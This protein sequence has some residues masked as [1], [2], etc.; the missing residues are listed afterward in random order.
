MRKIS[1]GDV[2]GELTC[3]GLAPTPVSGKRW[4]FRCACGKIVAYRAWQVNSGAV[5]SCGCRGGKWHIAP[6]LIGQTF[7]RL[8]VVSR[9]P[10]CGPRANWLC[11][12]RCG[13]TISVP[14]SHLRGGQQSCGC[15][16]KVGREQMIEK[17]LS[18]R[19]IAITGCWEWTGHVNPAG[20]GVV[21]AKS[22]GY[23]RAM[24]HRMAAHFWIGMPLGSHL[25]VCHRCDN[26]KCFNPDHLF[27]GTARDN[28]LD[29][30]A[31]GRMDPGG[32]R[33]HP[34]THCVNGHP[35]NPENRISKGKITACRECNR[36]RCNRY[37]SLKDVGAVS[38]MR[39][40]VTVR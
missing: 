13:E 26:R 18:R 16:L 5:N 35:V 23:A 30:M 38:A 39:L 3:I 40:A 14:T 32:R 21:T 7:G 10:N 37:R 11:R 15:I 17:L 6:D 34:R 33:Q 31:K 24:V 20:Y 36:I 1:V 22:F 4:L 28:A 19:H 8:T 27:M 25:M 12:C 9:L 2:F 29:A